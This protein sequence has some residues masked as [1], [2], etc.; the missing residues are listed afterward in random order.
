MTPLART[1]AATLEAERLVGLSGAGHIA[2]TAFCPIGAADGGILAAAQK[3][4]V[5][6]DPVFLLLVGPLAA[7]GC[8]SPALPAQ[9]GWDVRTAAD[10]DR[11]RPSEVLV[12]P[13]A[14]AAWVMLFQRAGARV[15]DAGSVLSHTAIVARAYGLTKMRADS[16]SSELRQRAQPR[17]VVAQT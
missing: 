15:A 2:F 7:D 17:V 10:L 14:T 6:F 16:R 3:A 9:A 11:L 8:Q 13:I 4:G 1:I 12:C 5:M